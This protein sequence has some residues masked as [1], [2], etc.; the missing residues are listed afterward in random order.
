MGA[1]LRVPKLTFCSRNA[2]FGVKQVVVARAPV[3]F[4]QR[5]ATRAMRAIEAARLC[6]A[7]IEV[8]K[9][10]TYFVRTTKT[11]DETQAVDVG[12]KDAAD[13]V[14]ARLR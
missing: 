12:A 1:E 9:D 10:G 11:P 8:R 2:L 13:V 4:R 3:R 14:T 5:E 7:G 6:V